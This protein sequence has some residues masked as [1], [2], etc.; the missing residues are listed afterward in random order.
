M[1]FNKL[2]SYKVA[3]DDGLMVGQPPEDGMEGEGK[4]WILIWKEE[5]FYFL[6]KGNSNKVYEV[7]ESD[8]ETFKKR[9]A[10]HF[11]GVEDK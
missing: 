6:E 2:D 8:W 7:K 3:L 9:A 11:L 4:K 1:D 10:D 5:G